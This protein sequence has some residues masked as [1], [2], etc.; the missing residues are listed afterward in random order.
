[1]NNYRF[2][3]SPFLLDCYVKNE[4]NYKHSNQT[5]YTDFM[6]QDIFSLLH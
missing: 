3:A 2:Y 1:M 5:F 6:I 4:K